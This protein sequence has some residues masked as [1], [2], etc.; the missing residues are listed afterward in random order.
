M[1]SHIILQLA[2]QLF[3][4]CSAY[5]H[6]LSKFLHRHSSVSPTK[7]THPSTFITLSRLSHVEAVSDLI[8]QDKL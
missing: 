6:P 5:D 4:D 3:S 8:S 7:I 2:L 1:S